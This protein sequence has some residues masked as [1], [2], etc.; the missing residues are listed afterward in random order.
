METDYPHK[1]AKKESKGVKMY[2]WWQI[3]IVAPSGKE[4]IGYPTQKP[5]ALLQRIIECASNEGDTVLDPF[6]GGGTTVAVAE[7]LRRGWIGIDQSVMAIKV[8]EMRL[9][10][11]QRD[12]L[13]SPFIVQLHKYDY[14][15]LRYQD[16]FEFETWIVQQFGGVP[17]SKQRGDFGIDGKTKDGVPIQVKRSDNIGRNVIDNLKSASERFDKTLFEANKAAGKSIGIIIAFSFGKGA[18]QE[19]ARLKNHDG[20]IIELVTVENVVPIAK[21]PKLI[22]TCNDLGLNAKKLREIEFIAVGES[23]S[24]IEFYAWDF[25]HEVENGFKADV[26][27][28]KTGKQTHAFKAGSYK[29]AVKVVDNEGIESVEV[30]TLTALTSDEIKK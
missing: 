14:D 17:N 16:A 15:T 20:V 6:V 22:L 13:D 1:L 11:P 3:P 2:D 12:L 10:K 7:R 4:R 25:N 9:K 5:E 30:I 21:K 24:G 19:V 8:T 29:V 28:D 23:E 18:I 27:I 26:M